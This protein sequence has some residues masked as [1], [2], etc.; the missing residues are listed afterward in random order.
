MPSE[1]PP[2]EGPALSRDVA[3]R[4]EAA[5][6]RRAEELAA[7]ATSCASCRTA[8]ESLATSSKQ[9]LDALGGMWDPWEGADHEG[10]GHVPALADAPATV[11]ALVAWLLA[12]SE[13][14]WASAAS[15]DTSA[16]DAYALTGVAAGRW[17]AALTLAGAY[18]IEPE[19]AESSVWATAQRMTTLTASD[20]HAADW[21]LPGQARD[22]GADWPQSLGT[23]ASLASE[24]RLA[25][26]VRVWDCAAQSLV[27]AELVDH[28]LSGSEA[29]SERLLTRVDALLGAGVA[30]QRAF[31]CTLG[32]DPSGLASAL[33][34]TDLSLVGS[35]SPG[36]RA[37]GVH[38]FRE[39]LASWRPLAPSVIS[40]PTFGTVPAPVTDE[41]GGQSS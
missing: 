35:D 22:F 41:V 19:A 10:A 3:A 15:A 12:S 20:T 38:L 5:A 24:P 7:R 14:D 33:L 23:P 8:L 37:L 40:T 34:T 32:S 18:G 25:P 21:H 1:L 4:T 6:A 16:G 11:P 30:D 36:V 17:S 29:L 31:R 26:A 27:K 39:D 2:L 13:R 9:R 28:T